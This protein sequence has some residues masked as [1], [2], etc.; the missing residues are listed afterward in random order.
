MKDL[1]YI[2]AI[3]KNKFSYYD[4]NTAIMLLK[5]AIN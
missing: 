5:N 4:L 3:V 1:F 2:R